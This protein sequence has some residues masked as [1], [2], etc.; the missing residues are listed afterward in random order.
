MCDAYRQFTANGRKLLSSA[1]LS[2]TLPIAHA[3]SELASVDS[4]FDRKCLLALR[5]ILARENTL[6][7]EQTLEDLLTQIDNAKS[8]LDQWWEQKRQELLSWARSAKDKVAKY[9]SARKEFDAER[10]IAES[11]LVKVASRQ[12]N[13]NSERATTRSQS[14]TTTRVSPA[15]YER[16][17]LQKEAVIAEYKR[18][19]T[20]SKAHSAV[21][22]AQV[23]ASRIFAPAAIEEACSRV[24]PPVGNEQLPESLDSAAVAKQ[25]VEDF[26]DLDR[27]RTELEKLSSNLP[28]DETFLRVKT[29]RLLGLENALSGVDALKYE[30]SKEYESLLAHVAEV[31]TEKGRQFAAG[32][33]TLL[34]SSRNGY[35]FFSSRAVKESAAIMSSA[36]YGLASFCVARPE[37][38]RRKLSVRMKELAFRGIALRAGIPVLAQEDHEWTESAL[39]IVGRDET[40][41]D[42]DSF[43]LE[44]NVCGFLRNQALAG[45]RPLDEHDLSGVARAVTE[46]AAACS[47][48]ENKPGVVVSYFPN[49][50]SQTAQLV[51][52]FLA[53]TSGPSKHTRYFCINTN[54]L[55]KGICDFAPRDLPRSWVDY[56]SALSRNTESLS[57]ELGLVRKTGSSEPTPRPRYSTRKRRPQQ[58]LSPSLPTCQSTRKRMPPRPLSPSMPKPK[59]GKTKRR[60]KRN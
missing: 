22:K 56:C 18:L 54:L 11:F 3:H 4:E 59:R 46:M 41:P 27:K 48:V 30:L 37:A 34:E 43:S 8:K 49:L 40:Y 23:E 12:S 50:P 9:F 53:L 29:S 42:L 19:V 2:R 58:P 10:P 44:A 57:V 5:S 16:M 55:Q 13:D 38:L 36:S 60:V 32:F 15:A 25:A 47:G 28:T 20:V 17:R 31:P 26:L 1:V 33:R 35:Y 14:N 21:Q 45:C 52:V 6:R 39:G 24:V 51:F 7:R